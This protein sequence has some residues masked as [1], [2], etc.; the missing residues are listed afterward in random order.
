MDLLIKGNREDIKKDIERHDE[1]LANKVS[2]KNKNHKNQK[3]HPYKSDDEQMPAN[4]QRSVSNIDNFDDDASM[5][6][7]SQF[8]GRLSSLLIPEKKLTVEERVERIDAG[9]DENEREIYAQM[10][11]QEEILSH[12]Y[13][14]ISS[15]LSDNQKKEEREVNLK[16]IND[17]ILCE[18]QL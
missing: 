16:E 5:R 15:T 8:G 7:G 11:D 3:E 4:E 1:Y 10:H 2:A 13:S 17:T 12:G 18:K 14:T 6:E 9:M